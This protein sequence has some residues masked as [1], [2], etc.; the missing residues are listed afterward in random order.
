MDDNA[1]TTE[2]G[3]HRAALRHPSLKI[4]GGVGALVLLAGIAVWSITHRAK[5]GS[6]TSSSSQ[7]GAVI[8]NEPGPVGAG[9]QPTAGGPVNNAP[10]PVPAPKPLP[11]PKPPAPGTSGG[12]TPTPKPTTAPPRGTPKPP[13]HTHSTPAK[14]S[15]PAVQATGQHGKIEPKH[16]PRKERG[17]RK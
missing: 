12:T 6:S 7:P 11:V 4:I 3:H 13:V 5:A 8:V 10:P 14:T 2:K 9:G 16:P 1:P 17:G 15:H